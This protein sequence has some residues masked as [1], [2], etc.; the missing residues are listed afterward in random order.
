MIGFV[1]ALGLEHSAELLANGTWDANDPQPCG[2]VIMLSPVMD[3]DA[4]PTE[5]SAL[6]AQVT[7]AVDHHISNYD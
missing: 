2:L 7:I 1:C 3:F 5:A 6:G 4:K